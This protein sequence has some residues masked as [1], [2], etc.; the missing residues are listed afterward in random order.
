MKKLNYEEFH[1]RVSEVSKAAKIFA[2]LTNNISEAFRIY[3]EVL[4]E[5]EV[6]VFI[7]TDSGD[8]PITAIDNYERPKC[9]DCQTELRIRVRPQDVNGKQW[10]TAWVCT[11][12]Q[13]EF[14]SEKTVGEWM[15]EL[16][17]ANVPEQ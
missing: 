12:C 4:S 14:Y 3:Q 7:S 9:P 13:A 5:E 15:R 6:K 11:N 1:K 17:K 16:R 2:P 8:R 10:N